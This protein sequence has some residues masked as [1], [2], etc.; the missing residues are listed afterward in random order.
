ME[1]YKMLMISPIVV[2]SSLE[3]TRISRIPRNC[4][5]K[6]L[7]IFLDILRSG[8]MVIFFSL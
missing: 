6:Y 2:F 1:P 4:S 5:L 3:V 8:S 7:G